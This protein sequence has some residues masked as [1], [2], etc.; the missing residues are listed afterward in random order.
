M[1]LLM[2]G[3]GNAPS[4]KPGGRGDRATSSARERGDEPKSSHA[5]GRREGDADDDH[6]LEPTPAAAAARVSDGDMATGHDL[7]TDGGG[8]GTQ[9]AGSADRRLAAHA[10][11]TAAAAYFKPKTSSFGVG[12][13]LQSM[14]ESASWGHFPI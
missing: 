10:A 12:L 1:F 9:L 11:D 4:T 14:R 8:V 3:R 5:H 13:R 6:D 7:D 2:L